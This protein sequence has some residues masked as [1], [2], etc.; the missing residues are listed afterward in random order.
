MPKLEVPFSSVVWSS[1]VLFFKKKRKRKQ[2]G[3][4]KPKKQQKT[5]TKEYIK[6]SVS[7]KQVQHSLSTLKVIGP[8]KHQ[9]HKICNNI[10]Q[11]G[12][13]IHTFKSS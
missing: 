1:A 5:Q 9:I 8:K 2:N 7:H 11:I 12:P 4:T 3:G 10:L 13:Q 6:R